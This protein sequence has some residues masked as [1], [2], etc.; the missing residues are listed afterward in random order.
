MDKK[1]LV[2]YTS[3]YGSTK[4]YAQWI[5]EALDA[6]LAEGGALKPIDLMGYD[7]VI[8]G[9]GLYAGGI[10][11]VRLVTQP[12]PKKTLKKTK[13]VVFT[14]GLADPETTDYSGIIQKAFTPEQREKISL[15]H[16][17]GGVDYSRLGNADKILMHMMKRHTQRKP[18]ADRTEDDRIFLETY[19]GQIDFSD[20][21]TISPLVEFVNNL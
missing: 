20:K 3:K 16:L 17:R 7:V 11:G 1:I 21:D 18:E 9:G 4:Q 19:G 15:F 2:A 8:Y 12:P 5:A 6:A 13:F 14:V 10:A